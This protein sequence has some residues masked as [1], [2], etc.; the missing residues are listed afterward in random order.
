MP[1]GHLITRYA[2]QQEAA[3]GGRVVRLDSPQ[4]RFDPTP[5]AGRVLRDVQAH[6]KR[7]FYGFEGPGPG[8]IH[9]HLGLRGFYLHTDD[10]DLPARGGTRLRLTGPHDAFSL[11]AP[12]TCEA[13]DTATHDA[14]VAALGPD[15]LRPA[16]PDGAPAVRAEAVRRL[17]AAGAPVATALTDQSVWAGIGNAWRAELLFLAGI[18]PARAVTEDE[19]G[20][21]WDLAVELLEPAVEAG[22]VV[23][24]PSAPDERWV[25]KR[26]TCRRCDAPVRR[27]TLASRVVHA[28]PV[29]QL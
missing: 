20:R 29:E 4:G 12:M 16:E 7:L 26:E 1:E 19:A 6:G 23:S 25:Y 3:L 13:V 17:V 9:V 21:L 8:F 15:P 5:F 11:V 28:C 2:R 27:W 10:P 22:Q 18:D 24:D 14:L